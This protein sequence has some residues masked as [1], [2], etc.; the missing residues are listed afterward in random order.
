MSVDPRIAAYFTTI[1][2]DLEAVE[3]LI[4]R[5]N[6]LAAFHMQQAI[7]KL[8]RSHLSPAESKGA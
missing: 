4:A 1:D 3:V 6:R 2:E 5:G 7:E 8:A